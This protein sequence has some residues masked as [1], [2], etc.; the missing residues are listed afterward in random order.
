MPLRSALGRSC[1][2]PLHE[3][4]SASRNRG[5]AGRKTEKVTEEGCS[6]PELVGQHPGSSWPLDFSLHQVSLQ[7]QLP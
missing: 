2:D 7:F 4:V 1:E 3:A 5:K 6:I